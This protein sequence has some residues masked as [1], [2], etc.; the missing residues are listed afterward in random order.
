MTKITLPTKSASFFV[1]IQATLWL[2]DESICE[3]KTKMLT[4]TNT[5]YFIDN[6]IHKTNQTYAC[7][8]N[9][10]EVNIENQTY[11]S[12]RARIL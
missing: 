12:Y 1:L 3:Q 5:T 9:A 11:L 8:E 10:H 4:D 2:L 6:E 7:Q